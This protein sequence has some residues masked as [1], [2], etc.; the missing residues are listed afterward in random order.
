MSV[1]TRP[2]S[3][4][5]VVLILLGIVAFV[6]GFFLSVIFALKE[7]DMPSTAT[8]TVGFVGGAVIG[9]GLVV[10]RIVRIVRSRRRT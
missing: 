8:P 3:G 4:M 2:R 10:A 5:G 7:F 1:P 6:V 9:C